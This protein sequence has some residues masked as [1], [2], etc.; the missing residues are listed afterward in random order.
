MKYFQSY[1]PSADA[2]IFAAW[3]SEV[4]KPE[5][6]WL[7]EILSQHGDEVFQRFVAN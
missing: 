6:F 5:N 3:D 2:A 1:T 4:C 7:R